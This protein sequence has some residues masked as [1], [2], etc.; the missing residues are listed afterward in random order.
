MKANRGYSSTLSLTSA[1]EGWV[2]TS[3]HR[4]LYLRERDPVP[5]VQKSGWAP[6]PVWTG[7]ENFAS[8]E[9]RSP[10]LPRSIPAPKLNQFSSHQ[11]SLTPV[12]ILFSCLTPKGPD[13]STRYVL[14]GPGIES[15][16]WRDFP[17]QFRPAVGPTQP[18]LQ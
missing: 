1:L 3:S 8:T 11:T 13:S 14:D 16:R 6:G 12:L 7:A 10:D 9:I 5:M 18:P 17:H 2:A 15:R 4:P